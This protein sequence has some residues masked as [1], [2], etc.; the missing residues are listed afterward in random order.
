MRHSVLIAIA[1]A[2]VVAVPAGASTPAQQLKA[3]KAKTAKLSKQL[4][5]AK[6][7]ISTLNSQ[8]TALTGNFA[9]AQTD[10]ATRTTERDTANAALAT[11][12]ASLAAQTILTGQAAAGYV[13][14]LS[15]DQLW[16]LIGVIYPLLPDSSICGYSRSLYTSGNYAS[17]SFTRYIC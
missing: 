10:L 2:L 12:N 15:P 16:A 7:K 8:I 14:G 1:L 4:A 3:Q 13:A 6:T 9:H 17:Y 5:A 11:A